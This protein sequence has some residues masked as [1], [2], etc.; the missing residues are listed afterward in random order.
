MT[1]G[2]LNLWAVAYALLRQA[3]IMTRLLRCKS[4]QSTA[5]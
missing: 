3:G 4:K 1:R 5:N 2:R